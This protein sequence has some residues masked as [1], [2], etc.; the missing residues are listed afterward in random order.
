MTDLQQKL[1]QYFC[2]HEFKGVDL[3]SRNKDGLVKWKCHKCK[4]IFIDSC[5][6]NILKNGKCIGVWS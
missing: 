3:T 6:L 1:K 2:K 5:G 4:K